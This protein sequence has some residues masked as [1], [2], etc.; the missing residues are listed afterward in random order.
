MKIISEN[1]F[2]IKNLLLQNNNISVSI[3][4]KIYYIL[5]YFFQFIMIQLIAYIL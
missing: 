2:F 3:V 4:K 5:V 1:K